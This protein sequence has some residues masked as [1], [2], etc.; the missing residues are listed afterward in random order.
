MASKASVLGNQD[1]YVLLNNDV[2]LPSPPR[3][4]RLPG[5]RWCRSAVIVAL[6]CL[7]I[8]TTLWILD[9]VESFLAKVAIP[10]FINIFASTNT[11]D[12]SF[13]VASSSVSSSTPNSTVIAAAFHPETFDTSADALSDL[14]KHLE[15]VVSDRLKK[16]TDHMKNLTEDKDSLLLSHA[17]L[18]G[19]LGNFMFMVASTWGV[20]KM[21]RRKMVL[22]A[23]YKM[24]G[25]FVHLGI[26]HVTPANF[27]GSDSS[28]SS[29][30]YNFEE[31]SAMKYTPKMEN[32][33]A[34]KGLRN[35]ILAGYMQSWKYF[36]HCRNDIRMLFTFSKTIFE[37]S[38]A[39]IREG[40]EDYYT[41]LSI[42]KADR[43]FS[44]QK[45]RPTLIAIH[46]RRGDIASDDGQ[47]RFGHKPATK[48]Y[49]LRTSSLLS[50][51]YS[52][53]IFLV[54]SNDVPYCRDLF[55]GPNFVVMDNNKEPA[56][57][58]MAII[59]L[60]DHII[61]SVGTFG[62]WAA[63]LSDA[64]EV[65][66]YK[67]WPKKGSDMEK[68]ISREDYFYPSWIPLEQSS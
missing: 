52:P 35:V 27:L 13:S 55:K 15:S 23:P 28:S 32:V 14:M 25:N 66:Y 19:G 22:L 3:L 60:A 26:D 2:D 9:D 1:G 43:I 17:I 4:S 39:K 11:L 67:D 30:E 6:T 36:D 50:Q 5:S 37:T 58:D 21:N 61:L 29:D 64:K 48:E 20:A 24:E 31:I 56:A 7:L 62:W 53:A 47:M 34:V 65:Y 12:S 10:S 57:V 41:H 18:Q 63:Y 46:V 44:D 68:Q 16:A 54:I 38:L 33:T 45:T 42:D 40:L 51:K 49:L 8:G 59:S